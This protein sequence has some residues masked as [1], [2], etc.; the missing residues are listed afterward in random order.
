MDDGE[1]GRN[2]THSFNCWEGKRAFSQRKSAERGRAS[3]HKKPITPFGD[4]LPTTQITTTPPSDQSTNRY[5]LR[6]ILITFAASDHFP[7]YFDHVSP[8]H[9]P[10]PL[11]LPF[12][13]LL[14]IPTDHPPPPPTLAFPRFH[15]VTSIPSAFSSVRCRRGWRWF[16]FPGPWPAT[17]PVPPA[18]SHGP[19]G[20]F[21]R[22]QSL[23][24]PTTVIL[25]SSLCLSLFG[26]GLSREW[27]ETETF[28]SLIRTIGDNSD[29]FLRDIP[30]C[31]P[32][33]PWS[34]TSPSDG[35]PAITMARNRYSLGQQKGLVPDLLDITDAKSIPISFSITFGPIFH[36]SGPIP[37]LSSV[38]FHPHVSL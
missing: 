38:K 29:H 16:R 31:S 20:R 5:K 18:P 28:R 30:Q 27:A 14:L 35:L 2:S 17:V 4:G 3:K 7:F 1:G 19:P 26:Y 24:I 25:R 8:D 33:R 34:S 37:D 13:L 36:C 23:P 6:L 9:L 10:H 22:P 21:L 11:C 32:P 12:S 15:S